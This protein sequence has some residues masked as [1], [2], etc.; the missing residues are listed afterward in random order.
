MTLEL[1]RM[2]VKVEGDG[3]PAI[4][5]AGEAI[6]FTGLTLHRSKLNLTDKPR[7]A[8]FMEYCTAPAHFSKDGAPVFHSPDAWIVSG[9]LPWPESD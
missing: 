1:W 5:R 7:R 4:M 6:A 8:F 9:Q 3:V 2:E